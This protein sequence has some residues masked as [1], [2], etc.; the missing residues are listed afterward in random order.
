MMVKG[1]EHIS[2]KAAKSALLNLNAQLATL[3]LVCSLLTMTSLSFYMV[4]I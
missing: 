2:W 3:T 4:S 1:E